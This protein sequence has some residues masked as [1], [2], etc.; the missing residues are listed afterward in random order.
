MECY[1][2]FLSHADHQIGRFIA[3]LDKIGKQKTHSYLYVLTMV[4]VQKACLQVFSMRCH[5]FNMK[6]ETVEQNLK[7]IDE[8]V[9]QH[10]TIIILLAGRW[11]VILH[12]SGTSNTLT[13]VG[14][15]TL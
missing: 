8:L 4:Q 9:D 6:P 15:K 14:Q 2:G 10:V 13:T 11:Q 3:F 5:V 12:L 7:R 1:A